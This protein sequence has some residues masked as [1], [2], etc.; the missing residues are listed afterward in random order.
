MTNSVMTGLKRGLIVTHYNIG[1]LAMDFL[2]HCLCMN[3]NLP[4]VLRWHKHR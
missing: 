1:H 4:Y 2:L 3:R